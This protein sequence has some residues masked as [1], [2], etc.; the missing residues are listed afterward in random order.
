[1]TPVAEQRDRILEQWF[2]QAV[3]DASA[4]LWGVRA[5]KDPPPGYDPGY[6]LEMVLAA[7]AR[8]RRA[9]E[10]LS[11]VPDAYRPW[12][13]QL[14][15]VWQRAEKTLGEQVDQGPGAL[16]HVAAEKLVLR[17]R[18]LGMGL[19]GV[20]RAAQ[21]E[22]LME[23]ASWAREELAEVSH[24]FLLR[25]NRLSL[26]AE[27]MARPPADRLPGGDFA[28]EAGILGKAFSKKFGS[29]HAVARFLPVIR[30]REYGLD[31][32]WLT[33]LPDEA[34]LPVPELPGDRVRFLETA[35]QEE[36][37]AAP[38]GCPH[39]ARTILYATDGLPPSEMRE[40]RGHLA[41][42]AYCRNLAGDIRLAAHRVLDL[43]M[44]K[45]PAWLG[46]AARSAEPTSGPA[47]AVTPPRR[48]SPAARAAAGL[49]AAAVLVL[50]LLLVLRADPFGLSSVEGPARQ[51]QVA[52]GPVPGPDPGGAPM[53]PLEIPRSVD[54]FV[55][56]RVTG[57]GPAFQ[58]PPGGELASGDNF[59]LR[60]GVPTDAWVYIVFI[61]ANS[62]AR[63][64]FQGLITGG[65]SYAIPTSGWFTLDENTGT[66]ILA[67]VASD[68]KIPDFADRV[69]D[70][71][72][73]GDL[74]RMFPG[75]LHKD[76]EFEH[77]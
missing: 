63:A 32:W 61:P 62:P 5:L 33:I 46:A 43:P 75:L 65:E 23:H 27:E 30:E 39:R 18:A 70:A 1:M 15:S 56:A 29:M 41:E 60:F 17:A 26:A 68:R 44:E 38:A 2:D 36:E 10:A 34:S 9:L 57:G 66:E 4:Y 35:F 42:C 20:E 48:L 50:V 24:D 55:D 77:Q 73:P 52:V 47:G 69:R 53:E 67:L 3:E 12:A 25:F 59:R 51:G 49:S 72:S 13:D 22:R 40:A 64:L 8:T 14:R 45:P 16:I 54:L 11:R 19:G 71:R 76:L 31:R 6:L 21:D 58:L 28:A 37:K 7:R 74:E